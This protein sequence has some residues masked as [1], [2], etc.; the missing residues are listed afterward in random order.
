MDSKGPEKKE[1]QRDVL[2]FI[3]SYSC[4]NEA[5]EGQQS[6]GAC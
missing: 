2:P 3:Q 6:E 1:S 5:T 4:M